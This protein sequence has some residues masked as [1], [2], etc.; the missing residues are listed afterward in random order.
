MIRSGH[1][2]VDGWGDLVVKGCG[3]LLSRGG[4][5]LKYLFVWVLCGIV[6]QGVVQGSMSVI[7]L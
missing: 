6:V 1:G 5:C 7:V 4:V 2:I 3:S